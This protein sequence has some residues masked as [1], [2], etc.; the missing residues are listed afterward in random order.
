[1][2]R[3]NLGNALQALSTAYARVERYDDSKAA[4]QR[5]ESLLAE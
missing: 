2:Q 3:P 1:M 5:F 4:H